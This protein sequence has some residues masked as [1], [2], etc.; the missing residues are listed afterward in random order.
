M[1]SVFDEL[2]VSAGQDVTEDQIAQMAGEILSSGDAM[3]NDADCR[4]SPSARLKNQLLSQVDPSRPWTSSR[5][6]TCR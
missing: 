3:M 6:S 5:G 4:P 1:G 2:A